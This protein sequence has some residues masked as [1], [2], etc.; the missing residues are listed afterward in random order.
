MYGD[1]IYKE[2]TSDFDKVYI[3]YYTQ[4]IKEGGTFKK[5]VYAEFELKDTGYNFTETLE[6]EIISEEEAM[7][8]INGEG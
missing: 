4:I 6:E 1:I 2:T 7:N 3:N 8:I 5:Y